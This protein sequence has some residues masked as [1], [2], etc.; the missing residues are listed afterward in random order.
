M[1]VLSRKNKTNITENKPRKPHKY[2]K[3]PFSDKLTMY[4]LKLSQYFLFF[5]VYIF[6]PKFKNKAINNDWSKILINTVFNPVSAH[7]LDFAYILT[8][9]QVSCA[10]FKRFYYC[11]TSLL[12]S[13]GDDYNSGHL[14]HYYKS[15]RE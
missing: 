6:V 5:T 10:N 1:P 9:L 2:F 14:N 11:F 8:R 15:F 4:L 12:C 13:V 7:K 3:S